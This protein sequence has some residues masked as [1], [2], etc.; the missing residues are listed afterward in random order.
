AGDDEDLGRAPAAAE[1]VDERL[2]TGHEP[3]IDAAD[4][5]AELLLLRELGRRRRRPRHA[6]GANEDREL[7]DRERG[8]GSIALRQ[9][10]A[11]DPGPADD[12]GGL[13]GAGSDALGA[14]SGRRSLGFGSALLPLVLFVAVMLGRVRFF[15]TNARDELG[16]F[17]VALGFAS[18]VVA[19]RVSLL[20][21]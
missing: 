5:E 14:R 6:A 21:C 11:L 19:R 15:A 17:L 7:L 1:V 8:D 10:N 18:V 9:R 20:L 12:L 13:L 2:E 16:E 3:G 4:A